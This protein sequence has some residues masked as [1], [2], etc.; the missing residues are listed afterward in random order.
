MNN[1]VMIKKSLDTIL[2]YLEYSK[3]DISTFNKEEFKKTNFT[4]KIS[5]VSENGKAFVYYYLENF[6]KN[7]FQKF[8]DQNI[9]TDDIKKE[10]IMIIITN[11]FTFESF[12]DI[13]KFKT[14]GIYVNLYKVE[15]LAFNILNHN[16]V[17]KHTKLS[18]KEKE[19]FMTK[20]N[21]SN[22]SIELP[23]ISRFDPVACAIFLRP[24]DICK[25]IRYDKISYENE[26]Y[27][28][29]VV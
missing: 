10:D 19:E 15:N 28:I 14:D 6:T 5:V 1:N 27:R 4:E 12:E 11:K 18:L 22:P 21:V 3:Y 25:I 9:M 29:C 23:E 26:Y 20:F 24:G 16:Y 8:I 17:P 13:I 2:E 7:N